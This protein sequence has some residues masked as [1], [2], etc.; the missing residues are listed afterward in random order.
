MTAEVAIT[1]ASVSQDGAEVA[2]IEAIT[3]GG[4]V[5]TVTVDGVPEDRQHPVFHRFHVRLLSP[6]RMIPDVL[7]E[8]G[9]Y[10][11]AVKIGVAFAERV[12]A[13][14]E[15]IAELREALKDGGGG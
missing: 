8:A 13:N 7:R 5:Q 6:D 1:G 11:D 4:G 15:R 10:E 12:A 3:V 2:R 9:T 14:A